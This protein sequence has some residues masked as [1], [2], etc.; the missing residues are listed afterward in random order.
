MCNRKRAEEVN[1]GEWWQS[2]RTGTA[3][4][5]KRQS[6]AVTYDAQ[7]NWWL[8]R[9]GSDTNCLTDWHEKQR[10]ETEG[11]KKKAW[12]RKIM[13]I[14]ILI[15]KWNQDNQGVAVRKRVNPKERGQGTTFGWCTSASVKVRCWRCGSA[16]QMSHRGDRLQGNR[17][18]TQTHL[19]TFVHTFTDRWKCRNNPEVPFCSLVASSFTT[20]ASSPFIAISRSTHL[21]EDS[22]QIRVDNLLWLH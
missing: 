8:P 15:K 5:L 19:H 4:G 9:G 2:G 13:W 6:W 3:N 11:C 1:R 7:L 14:I 20:L 16:W 10:E 12:R 17:Q 21:S 18:H 22:V